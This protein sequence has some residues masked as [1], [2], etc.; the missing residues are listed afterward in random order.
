MI[1]DSIVQLERAESN[2]GFVAIALHNPPPNGQVAWNVAENTAT[3]GYRLH[4]T[5]KRI[6]FNN[7]IGG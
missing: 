2:A 7:S 1:A 4:Q 6:I 3:S 5:T